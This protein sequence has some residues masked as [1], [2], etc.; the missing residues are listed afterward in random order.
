V[1]RGGSFLYRA[2]AVRSSYRVG[3]RPTDRN[4][5]IGFRVARSVR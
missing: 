5:N 2:G 1:I 3:A 4:D